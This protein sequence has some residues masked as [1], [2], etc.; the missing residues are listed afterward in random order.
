[1]PRP[2]K[3]PV[4]LLANSAALVLAI[5]ADTSGYP[6]GCNAHIFPDGAFRADDG[7]PASITGGEVRDWQMDEAIAADLIALFEASGKPVLYDYE[8][9]SLYGDSRAAGWIDKLV[10]VPGRGVYAHVEWTPQAAE[11]IAKK[12]YRYSSPYFFFDPKTGAV[13]QLIST[14]LTNNPALGDLGAVGLRRNP[15]SSTDKEAENMAD[16]KQVAA[17]TSE[18]DGLKTEVA[19]LTNERDGLKGQVAALT[20]ER[21]AQKAKLD[22]LEK[23]KAEAALASE[24]A[25][26]A[27]LLAAALKDGRLVPA[28]KP[29]AEKQ[30]LAALTEY[31]EATS[32]LVGLKR[33]A[34]G[35]GDGGHG[36]TEDQLAMCSTMGVTPDQFKAAQAQA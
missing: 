18:R 15:V 17:L 1:M 20:A 33:Q 27:E 4:A 7:R 3:F 31:L 14:A 26:H 9:N 5:D 16:E 35:Q 29:W 28:Q 22:A 12:V 30:T 24:K 36:L 32:P 25:K 34:D 8:H 13:K 19:A 6:A 21:D 11:A 10:Y 2:A 23:E